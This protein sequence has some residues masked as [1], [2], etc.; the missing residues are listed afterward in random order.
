MIAEDIRLTEIYRVFDGDMRP[1]EI[2]N[3]YSPRRSHAFV[4]FVSGE[5]GYKFS[6]YSFTASAGNVIHLPKGSRYL[7][8][9]REKTSYI[10]VDFDGV[11]ASLAEMGSV[12]RGIPPS[13]SEQFEQMLLAWYKREPSS[14]ADILSS[15]YRVISECIAAENKRYA[16]SEVLSRAIRHILSDFADADLTVGDIAGKSRVSE[17]H[18]RRLFKAEMGISPMAYVNYL[19]FERARNMLCESNITVSGIA[20]LSGFSDPYYFSREFKR[21]FGV[22]PSEYKAVRAKGEI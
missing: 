21:R 15:C 10:C 12:C 5:V 4:Y 14:V 20:E 19:R 8:E 9:I 11:G 7:M 13:V 2:D 1:G 3:R 16:K 18:L 17:A 22:A 6:D